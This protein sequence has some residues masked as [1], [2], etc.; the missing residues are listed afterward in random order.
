[1]N[2]R[3]LQYVVA[4]SQDRSF[5]QTAER[6]GI[7]QPALSK[8]ILALEKELGVRLFNRDTAPITLTTAGEQ[9]VQEAK[10]L[11]FRE[12]H[13]LHTMERFR[14]GQDIRITIGITPFRSLYLM[15]AIVRRLGEKF[16]GIRVSL[17]EYGSNV[18][19]REIVD[20][21]YDCESSGG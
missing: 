15:P 19:R 18:L 14:S 12:D 9:F 11:L 3:Q 20:G 4:L 1:M 5:S 10:D 2:S 8:Q 13:L 21:K 6:L 17:Q 16:P 7:S